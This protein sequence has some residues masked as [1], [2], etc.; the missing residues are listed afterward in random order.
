[1]ENH[2]GEKSMTHTQKE[3]LMQMAATIAAG[4]LSFPREKMFTFNQIAK[5]SIGI[6]EEIVGQINEKYPEKEGE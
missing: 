3:L 4:I 2:C 6:A 5:D 1:M